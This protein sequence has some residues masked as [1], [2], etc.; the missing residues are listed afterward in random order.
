MN[1]F[2]D[3]S[4]SVATHEFEVIYERYFVIVHSIAERYHPQDADD[5][6]ADIFHKKILKAVEKGYFKKDENHIGLVITIAKR[7]CISIYNRNKATKLVSLEEEESNNSS[8][9]N[10]FENP[11]LRI[12][13]MLDVK[14]ALSQLSN[15]QHE[16][17]KL[18]IEGYKDS[19]IAEVMQS[20]VG[21]VRMLRKRARTE[22]KK[23]L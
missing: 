1:W 4:E 14:F 15:K 2:Y 3:G 20:S 11:S 17:M 23:F 10:L 9:I 19:E 8:G 18:T 12:D 22:L 7:Y 16:V 5:I 21:A 6:T 13:L